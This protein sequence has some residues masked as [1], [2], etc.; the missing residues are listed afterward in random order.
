MGRRAGGG[1]VEA[2]ARQPTSSSCAR[3]NSTGWPGLCSVGR[4]KVPWH[5]ETGPC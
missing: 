3:T 1:A 4:A 5:L 2:A